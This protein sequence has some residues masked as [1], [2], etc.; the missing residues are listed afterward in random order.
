MDECSQ[1]LSTNLSS[2]QPWLRQH[3]FIVHLMRDHAGTRTPCVHLKKLLPLVSGLNAVDPNSGLAK[4]TLLSYSVEYRSLDAFC[5][6]L[7]LGADLYMTQDYA[8]SYRLFDIMISRHLNEFLDAMATHCKRVDQMPLLDKFLSANN[9]SPF[10]VKAVESNNTSIVYWYLL[11]KFSVDVFCMYNLMGPI[12]TALHHGYDDMT[13]L[14]I[15]SGV[16]F[17]IVRAPHVAT[18]G[19]DQWLKTHIPSYKEATWALLR[20]RS[21]IRF[22]ETVIY[23]EP[24]TRPSILPE[25]RVN[26]YSLNVSRI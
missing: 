13:E 16:P 26:A 12:E 9:A 14:L 21:I 4:M 25:L 18:M 19:P 24:L 8:S 17:V 7:D 11:Q 5:I 6:L 3:E 22:N 1:S 10:L 20:Q 23:A 2:D 15:N